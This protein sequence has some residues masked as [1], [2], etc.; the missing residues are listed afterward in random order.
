MT[1][2]VPFDGSP[3]AEATLARAVEFAAALEEAVV[4]R[5]GSQVAEIAPD[6]TF[7]CEHPE[8]VS[9]VASVTTGRRSRGRASVGRP[10]RRRSPAGRA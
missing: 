4:D 9:S 7:R 2:L 1:Y 8:D 3:L 6:A 5:L 10:S